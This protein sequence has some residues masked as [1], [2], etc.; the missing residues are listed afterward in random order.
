MIIG[1]YNLLTVKAKTDQGYTLMDDEHTPIKM[2]LSLS[3]GS[4]E[5][6][7]EVQVLVFKSAQ[8][9]LASDR[10]GLITI[11]GFANLE[12]VAKG[13]FHCE[14]DMGLDEHTLKVPLR[15]QVQNMNIGD[16]YLVHHFWDEEMDNYIGSCKIDEFLIHYEEAE[17]KPGQAV[18]LQAYKF[19]NLG[20][21]VIVDDLY[22]GLLYENEVFRD[23]EFGEIL[24]GYIKKLRD[25]KKI[26][27][28]L[29]PFGYNKV[30]SGVPKILEL[31]EKQDGTLHLGDKS[32]PESIA[33]ILSMSKKTFKKAIG[34]LYKEGKITIEPKS[35]H[36][37]KS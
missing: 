10:K 20:I 23:V 16:H 24:S 6:G 36:L 33:L 32:D 35:I 25:D 1:D 18:K 17:Y 9:L 14:M 2:P 31:L 15:E 27:V 30:V 29:Q 22:E 4:Y 11:N 26:D 28:T 5:I 21:K 19:T 13:P 34:H 3:K 37:V 8:E 12:L 7:D